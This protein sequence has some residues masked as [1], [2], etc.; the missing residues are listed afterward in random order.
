[1]GHRNRAL[2][3]LRRIAGTTNSV[4]MR[5]V[6]FAALSQPD[7]RLVKEVSLPPIRYQMVPDPTLTRAAFCE[8]HN[9]VLVRAL[10]NAEATMVLSGNTNLPTFFAAWSDDGRYLG[11]K[12]NTGASGREGELEVLGDRNAT[13]AALQSIAARL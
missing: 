7:M 1:M 10:T 3:A 13:E 2:E 12:R 11:V 8:G 5:R 9:P 4:E 6:A